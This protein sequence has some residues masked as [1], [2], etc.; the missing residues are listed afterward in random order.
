MTIQEYIKDEISKYALP[1][2]LEDG[3]SWSMKEHL[4]KAYLYKNS[5]FCENNEDR[6]L[7]PFKNILLP[8]LNLQYRTEGFDVK[9]IDLYVD[10]RDFYHLSFIVTKFHEKWAIENSIDTFIDELVESYVDYG[11]SLVRNAGKC[12]E[13]VDLR[14]IAFCNQ[15]DILNYPFAIEHDLSDT[16]LKEKNW[17]GEMSAEDLIESCDKRNIYEIHGILPDE[18]A[19]FPNEREMMIVAIYTS[20][21][22][23]EKHAILDSKRVPK[24]LFKL[25]KRDPVSGRALGRGSIEES[26]DAQE[27]TNFSEVKVTEMLEASSKIFFKNT[28]PT[29]KTNNLRN[30][31][32]LEVLNLKG[33][34]DVQQL[35]TSPRNLPVFNDAMDRWEQRVQIIAS[36]NEGSLQ[37]ETKSGMPFKLFEAQQIEGKGVHNYRQGKISVFVSEIYHEWVMSYITREL[38][39]GQEFLSELSGDEMINIA[40]KVVNSVSNRFVKDKILNAQL[41]NSEEIMKIKEVAKNDFL[42]GGNKKF[43]QILKDEFKEIGDVIKTNIAN[44]QKNLAFLTDQLVNVVRQFISTPEIR[45]DPE[46]IKLLNTI[47]ESSGVSPIMFGTSSPIAQQGGNTQPLKELATNAKENVKQTA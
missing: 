19:E 27:W 10:N 36:A 38:R 14:T 39:S 11:G 47:L 15:K 4:R 42:K 28:D 45:Q 12:P 30:M 29:F 43:I 26:T 7:R 3:W 8:I 33:G 22:G 16:Q 41:I 40:D 25:L 24:P 23:E 46:M 6:D 13:V 9:D 31:D 37:G 18:I 5:Q 44:K 32:N 34:G 2:D 17:S 20:K 21:T 1:I 35:D